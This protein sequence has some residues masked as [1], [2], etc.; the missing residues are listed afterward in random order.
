MG[1]SKAGDVLA[2]TE[3]VVRWYNFRGKFELLERLD[4][5]KVPQFGDEESAKRAAHALG[6]K[7][8][9]YVPI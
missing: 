7:T 4:L 6:L 3:T 5:S 2:T 9:V 8:S 1:A